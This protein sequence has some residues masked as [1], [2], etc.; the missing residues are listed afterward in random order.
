MRKSQRC[1]GG[2]LANWGKSLSRKGRF[3]FR[4]IL[5]KRFAINLRLRNCSGAIPVST[6]EF[7]A[8]LVQ[9]A[10]VAMQRGEV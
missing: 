1:S 3:G 2:F 9:K 4:E 10:P 8:G 6:H 7:K 5:D